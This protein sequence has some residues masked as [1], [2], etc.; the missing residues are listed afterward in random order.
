[1]SLKNSYF[2]L[3]CII[4]TQKSERKKRMKNNL[5]LLKGY[6]QRTRI[7]WENA[8]DVTYMNLKHGECDGLLYCLENNLE[9]IRLLIETSKLVNLVG[10]GQS[11]KVYGKGLII[12]LETGLKFLEEA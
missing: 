2:G 12:G 3:K 5:E 9:D 10:E 8:T 4:D 7:E 11:G 6:A 1:M